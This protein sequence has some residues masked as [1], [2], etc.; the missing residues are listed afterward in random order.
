LL[1]YLLSAVTACRQA[2]RALSLVLVEIDDFD[3]LALARGPVEA[4]NIVWRMA[5]VCRTLD[6]SQTHCV[7]IGQASF[8]IIL[9]NCDRRQAV[10]LSNQVIR[11]NEDSRSPSRGESATSRV[12]VSVGIATVPL[13]PKNFSP[14]DLFAG[15]MRCLSAARLCGGSSLKSIEVL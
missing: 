7:Q 10:E 3:D 12:T 5:G 15:A 13:L 11:L 2:R 6:F 14:A 1:G 8:A 4:E 9:K